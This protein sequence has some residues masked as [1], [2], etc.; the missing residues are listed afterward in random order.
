MK[1]SELIWLWAEIIHFLI[2]F[3]FLRSLFLLLTWMKMYGEKERVCVCVFSLLLMGPRP[4]PPPHPASCLLTKIPARLNGRVLDWLSDE[5][6]T[7]LWEVIPKWEVSQT[8]IA[9]FS[10]C[11][12]VLPHHTASCADYDWFAWDGSQEAPIDFSVFYQKYLFTVVSMEHI[13]TEPIPTVP[14]GGW[15]KRD[16]SPCSMTRQMTCN[17]ISEMSQ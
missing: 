10:H 7:L 6:M 4:T 16:N 11:H 3:L 8:K 14:N 17:I 5:M 1:H 9:P 15:C 13:Q 12:A 2:S